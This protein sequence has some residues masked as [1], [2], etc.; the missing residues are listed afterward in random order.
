MALVG[1]L[2][3]AEDGTMVLPSEYLEVVITK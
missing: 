2:N 3:R 1:T